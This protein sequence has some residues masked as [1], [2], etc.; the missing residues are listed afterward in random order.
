MIVDAKGQLNRHYSKVCTAD[1][2][3]TPPWF[4]VDL[5]S[6]TSDDIEAHLCIPT[7]IESTEVKE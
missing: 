1:E 2:L 7:N 4:S 5:T 6:P 3:Q